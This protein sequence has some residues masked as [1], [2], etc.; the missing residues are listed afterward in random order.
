MTTETV[1]LRGI[2]NTTKYNPKFMNFVI[3]LQKQRKKLLNLAALTLSNKTS[4][5]RRLYFLI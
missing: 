3:K 2:K 5:Q 4:K 1:K